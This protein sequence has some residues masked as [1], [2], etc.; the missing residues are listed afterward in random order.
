M[1]EDMTGADMAFAVVKAD[2]AEVHVEATA[3]AWETVA[4]AGAGA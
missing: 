1:S 4:T 2:P 3:L